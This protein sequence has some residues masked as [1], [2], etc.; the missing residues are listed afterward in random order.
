MNKVLG[1]H[2]EYIEYRHERSLE[3]LNYNLKYYGTT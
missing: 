3:A 1:I 2:R